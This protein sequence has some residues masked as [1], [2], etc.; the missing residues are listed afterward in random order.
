MR[1]N[2]Y[3][4]GD[5]DERYQIP[6]SRH[7]LYLR[8]DGLFSP[9]V[10]PGEEV[11][12]LTSEH[13]RLL[14]VVYHGQALQQMTFL[15]DS[16]PG[17][18]DWGEAL[19]EVTLDI[20]EWFTL[21]IDLFE[22][23]EKLNRWITGARDAPD[24]ILKSLRHLHQTLSQIQDFNLGAWSSSREENLAFLL[25]HSST[26]L[27]TANEFLQS[28]ASRSDP[29][30]AAKIAIAE[31]DSLLAVHTFAGDMERGYWLRP[32]SLAAISWAG[33][34]ADAFRGWMPHI[35]DRAEVN[36]LK[37]VWDY[38]W[39][40]PVLVYTIVVRLVV[41]KAFSTGWRAEK[42]RHCTEIQKHV[43]VLQSVFAKMWSGIRTLDQL[44]DLQRRWYQ[45]TGQIPLVAADIYGGYYL[46]GTYF[47]SDFRRSRFGPG[48]APPSWNVYDEPPVQGVPQ[49]LDW[50]A[51]NVRMFA[52]HWWNLVYLKIGMDDLLLFISK[53]QAFCDEPWFAHLYSEVHGKIRGVSINEQARKRAFAAASL[54][55]LAQ[56][57]EE[58][59]ASTAART[60]FLYEALET[61][62]ERAEA[63]VADCI[64]DLSQL[65]KAEAPAGKIEQPSRVTTSAVMRR[66]R[67]GA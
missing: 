52:R 51:Y 42:R 29:V 58:E 63:I 60:H 62:G 65:T 30:W 34:A 53:L 6:H 14:D 64:R 25:A 7:Q 67:K 1:Q 26:A 16:S 9:T 3:N 38:R 66:K 19:K 17:R 36:F 13:A 32:E 50:V 15:K 23:A 54:S 22:F 11:L 24:P 47:A 10:E 39:A 18:G 28:E 61:G 48:V 8:S 5:H 43:K 4:Q 37:Q 56:R 49:D 21:G 20:F 33:N 57:N 2:K 59:P 35:T 46:G 45:S 27:H 31:R 44:S 40:L 12:E 41:L 55:N